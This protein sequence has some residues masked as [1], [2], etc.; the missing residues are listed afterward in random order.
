MAKAQVFETL[1]AANAKQAAALPSYFQKGMAS[2]SY[3]FERYGNIVTFITLPVYGLFSWVMFQ[4]RKENFAEHLVIMVFA[5]AQVSTINVLV[6]A[7]FILFN[8]TGMTVT[9]VGAALTVVSF[10]I[11]Y[12]QFYNLGIG[13]AVWK[14][15]V[16]YTLSYLV[17]LLLFMIALIAYILILKNSTPH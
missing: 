11:T 14:G 10:I 17:Q 12:K 5:F 15:I 2:I 9:T 4:K 8:I 16:I 3:V 13:K 1:K 7:S 6:Y